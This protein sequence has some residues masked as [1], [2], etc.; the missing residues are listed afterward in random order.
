MPGR[1][2]ADKLVE[3]R[4]RALRR[5]F[6]HRKAH[7]GKS[8]V[9]IEDHLA[10]N[11]KSIARSIEVHSANQYRSG[12]YFHRARDSSLAVRGN[13]G[14][15][16]DQQL[17]IHRAGNR[18]RHRVPIAAAA[19]DSAPSSGVPLN[20]LA[21][22]FDP[23]KGIE[24]SLNELI[25]CT[26]DCGVR[27]LSMALG[28]AHDKIM[29]LEAQLESALML[30][31]D[32]N[33]S[34]SC[35]MAEWDHATSSSELCHKLDEI[36]ADVKL[37]LELV[38][39]AVSAPAKSKLRRN[40]IAV[41][42]DNSAGMPGGPDPEV[43]PDNDVQKQLLHCQRT[44]L[45]LRTAAANAAAADSRH[46]ELQKNGRLLQTL[47]VT[48]GATAAQHDI[49]KLFTKFAGAS[50]EADLSE[51]YLVSRWQLSNLR[52]LTDAITRGTHISKLRIVTHTRSRCQAELID[53]LIEHCST[54][55]L[56][57]ACCYQEGLHLREMAFSN[58]IVVTCDRGLD[59][60]RGQGEAADRPCRN[61]TIHYFEIAP[62]RIAEEKNVASSVAAEARKQ[63]TADM[64]DDVARIDALVQDQ[65]QKLT[66]KRQLGQEEAAAKKV[67]QLL[68][69]R[70]V[71]E[72]L[73]GMRCSFTKKCARDAIADGFQ[74]SAHYFVADVEACAGDLFGEGVFLRAVRSWKGLDYIAEECPQDARFAYD[75]PAGRWHPAVAEDDSYRDGF[76]QRVGDEQNFAHTSGDSEEEI[77][78]PS[79]D[80]SELPGLFPS[81]YALFGFDNEL[82][83]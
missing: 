37:K 16:I 66:R 60:Y 34:I 30:I 36:Y 41:D 75:D 81:A 2:S 46:T 14:V 45:E 32:Q 80:D 10:G 49:G 57:V 29:S 19:V 23:T 73:Q 18:G 47:R 51:P 13:A 38:A 43:A 7:A 71:D 68:E 24:L 79:G 9:L 56:S 63:L 59:I 50:N 48:S 5:G 11:L 61:A 54:A 65:K 21:H 82:G 3:R 20:P 22:A 52:S 83:E 35:L 55:G 69:A 25:G 39:E 72:W 78:P 77:A 42:L 62:H 58:G 4:L 33:Y 70:Q 26:C 76:V 44:I 74:S 27:D 15:C 8:A 31:G 6:L 28:L 40:Q 64:V 53:S 12:Q 67:R 17:Q 1:F